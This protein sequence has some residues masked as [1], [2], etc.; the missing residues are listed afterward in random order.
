MSMSGRAIELTVPDDV[1]HVV[2]RR[3]RVAANG[4][5]LC[6]DVHIYFTLDY[7]TI[8]VDREFEG[9]TEGTIKR[10]VI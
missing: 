3:E 5:C 8:K 2:V 1:G 9:S 7:P 4:R 6:E 10:R